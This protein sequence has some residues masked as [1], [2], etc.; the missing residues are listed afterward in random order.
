MGSALTETGGLR[1]ATRTPT[2]ILFLIARDNIVSRH[3]VLCWKERRM[4]V[5]GLNQAQFHQLQDSSV[6]PCRGISSP[7]A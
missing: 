1:G 5:P 3:M 7:T 2:E 6:P 4:F